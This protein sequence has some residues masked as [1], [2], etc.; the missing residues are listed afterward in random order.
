MSATAFSRFIVQDSCRIPRI[1]KPFISKDLR[2]PLIA[3][4]QLAFGTNQYEYAIG[5]RNA[6]VIAKTST[7]QVHTFVVR[8]NILGVK[9]GFAAATMLQT[10]QT[11]K[12]SNS[13]Y[14]T[15][16][17][18]KIPGIPTYRAHQPSLIVLTSTSQLAANVL[19][20]LLIELRDRPIRQD[21]RRWDHSCIGNG[22]PHRP[23]PLTHCSILPQKSRLRDFFIEWFEIKFRPPI[24]CFPAGQNLLASVG[25][26]D[27]TFWTC[28]EPDNAS[29]FRAFARQPNP[30]TQD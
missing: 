22:F 5:T 18:Q 24:P 25:T 29:F 10:T 15:H 6:P 19:F 17:R 23:E 16:S 4:S 21:K 1:R 7:G 14:K 27:A 13:P 30:G 3:I 11:S 2:F 9:P 28:S 26:T 12:N 20:Q 8:F